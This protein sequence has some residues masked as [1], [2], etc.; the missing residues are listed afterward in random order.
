M[1][2]DVHNA[3]VTTSGLTRVCKCLHRFMPVDPKAVDLRVE[4]LSIRLMAAKALSLL[5]DPWRRGN[6]FYTRVFSG[7]RTVAGQGLVP[8]SQVEAQ[9]PWGRAGCSCEGRSPREQSSRGALALSVLGC[10]GLLRPWP[11]LLSLQAA[12]FCPG[13][14]SKLVWPLGRS[15]AQVHE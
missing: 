5:G 13:Q 1:S 12:T 2:N 4:A 3:T 14:G 9:Q 10:S 8:G 11:F 15:Q 7:L 6:R